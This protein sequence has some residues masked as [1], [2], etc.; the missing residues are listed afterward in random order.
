[1]IKSFIGVD[2]IEIDRIRQ[3]IDRWGDRFLKR[4]Y[5]E[6]EL[7]LCAGRTESLA[8]RFS[9]KEAVIK[10]LNPPQFT[11]SWTDIEILAGANGEPLVVLSGE[12]R[13]QAAKLGLADIRVSLSHSRDNAVAMAIGIGDKNF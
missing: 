2:I 11:V 1:M 5:T 13:K 6:A 12:L 7:A 10:A 3:A 8:A 4:I 9:G